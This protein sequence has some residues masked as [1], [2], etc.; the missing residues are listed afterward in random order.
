MVNRD[1]PLLAKVAG[2]PDIERHLHAAGEALLSLREH[3]TTNHDACLRLAADLAAL[4]DQRARPGDRELASLLRH[5][6][7]DEQA[8]R[9]SRRR[10]RADLE[11]VADLIEGSVDMGFGGVLDLQTGDVWPEAVLDDWVP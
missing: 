1:V 2:D 8:G 11:Q 10:I 5:E 7:R 6:L 3:L 4:L 9:P